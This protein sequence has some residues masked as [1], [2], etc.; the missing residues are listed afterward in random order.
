MHNRI[1]RVFY[2]NVL[3]VYFHKICALAYIE[4]RVHEYRQLVFTLIAADETSIYD[5]NKNYDNTEECISDEAKFAKAMDRLEALLQ[6]TP[7]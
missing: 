4:K 7:K 3:L 6:K 5:Q 2:R 1:W